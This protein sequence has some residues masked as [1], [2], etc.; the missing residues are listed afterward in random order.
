M[1]TSPIVRSLGVYFVDVGQGDATIVLTPDGDAVVFDCRDAH[2]VLRLLEH[3][4]V[5]RLEALILSHLDIDH[6]A[7]AAEV[8][9]AFSDRIGAVYLSIDRDISGEGSDARSAKDLVDLARR[10]DDADSWILYPSHLTQRPILEGPGWSIR[11]VAPKYRTVIDRERSGHWED[12]NRC[13][14]VLRI[15]MG[16]SAVL[17]GGDAPLLTWAEMSASDRLAGV[18]R[19]PHHGGALDDGGIPDGWSAARLYQAVN[20]DSTAVSVGT[21]NRHGHPSVDWLRPAIDGSTCRLMCTQ[22]T[23]RCADALADAP[24]DWRKLTVPESH[25]TWKSTHHAEP[26]WRHLT[27]K[28]GVRRVGK[29]GE[30]PCAGTV[31]VTLRQDGGVRVAP[32]ESAHRAVCALWG[33]SLCIDKRI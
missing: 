21:N 10:G 26:P 6:I 23:P 2:P 18:F 8:L 29:F 19:V 15:E 11:L 3:W 5:D 4:K 12:V 28:T 31:V 22:V 32:L 33:Q 13:S 7:G 9:Q 14:S 25:E 24:A 30:V 1:V 16:G 20:P 27:K 17:V